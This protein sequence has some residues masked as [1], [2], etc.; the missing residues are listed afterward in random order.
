M[1]RRKWS[2]Q[3][4]PRAASA[5]IGWRIDEI[6]HRVLVVEMA[7]HVL[8]AGDHAADRRHQLGGHGAAGGGVE[9]LV[10]GAAESRLRPRSSPRTSPA[11]SG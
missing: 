4:V 2:G 8:V 3:E 10:P 9:A 6:E 11:P 1:V 7:D 5:S